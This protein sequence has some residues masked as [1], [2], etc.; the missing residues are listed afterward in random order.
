MKTEYHE[1]GEQ[2]TLDECLESFIEMRKS[3]KKP[4]TKNALR[5]LKMKLYKLSP[6]ELE[7]KAMLLQSE[8]MNWQTV[9]PI[10]TGT[11]SLFDEL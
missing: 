11:N 8:A 1:L 9:Y 4:M 2:M 5:L 6:D 3:I 10:K 7:Q